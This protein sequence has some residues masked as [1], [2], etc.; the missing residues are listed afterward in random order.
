MLTIYWLVM[1]GKY[2]IGSDVTLT[3]P[4]F[5]GQGASFYVALDAT[6]TLASAPHVFGKSSVFTGDHDWFILQ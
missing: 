4:V 2:Y 5:A 1:Q 6:L 3:K